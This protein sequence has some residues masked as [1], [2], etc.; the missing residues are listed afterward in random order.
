MFRSKSLLL[1]SFAI[2]TFAAKDV[3]A[4]VPYVI[5]HSSGTYTPIT[6]GTTHAPVAYGGFSALDEGSVGIPIPFSFLW[7]G[8]SYTTVHAYTNGLVSF[9]PPPASLAGQLRQ[10]NVVPSQGNLLHNFIGVM[11]HDLLMNMGTSAIRSQVTGAAGSRVLTIQFEDF[12]GFSNPASTVNFQVRLFEGSNAVQVKFGPN[13]LWQQANGGTTAIENSDGTDGLNLMDPSPT[14][15]A[16]CAC[17]PARC[18]TSN[19]VVGHTIDI[20]LPMV[21][22]LTATISAPPGARANTM[23]DAD[24]EIFNSGLTAAGAFQYQIYLTPTNTS[25]AG[26]TSIGTFSVPS[27][28]SAT[29]LSRT[30]T[31]TVPP[32]FPVGTYY[33]AVKVDTQFLINEAREDNNTSFSADF[34]TGPD[35][36]GSILPPSD[37]GPGEPFSIAFSVRSLGAPV[38]GPIS[39]QIYLSATQTFDMMT[40]IPVGPA[41]IT[42]T[43]GFAFDGNVSVTMPVSVPPSPPRYYVVAVLDDTNAEV[44]LD[45]TNNVLV[46]PN[47]V[48]VRGPDIEGVSYDSGPFAFRGLTYPSTVRLTNSGGA[49]AIDFTVCVYLSD[50]LLI[51]VTSDTQLLETPPMT[52]QPGEQRTLSLEPMIPVQTAT[53]TWYIAA[54]L[55]CGE[56]IPEAVETNNTERR[57]DP[58]TVRDPSPDLLP[59]AIQA[60]GT[61]AAAETTPVTVDYGNTGN[62]NGTAVIR[63]SLSDNPGITIDDPVLL[64]TTMPVTLAPTETAAF[65]DWVPLPPETPSGTYYIGAIID[66]DNRADETYEDNNAIASGPVVVTGTDL[67]IVTP[68]PP[69]AIYDVPYSRRFAAVGGSQ[70]Y[71]WTITWQSGSAP[72]GLAFD[73]TLAEISGTPSRSAEGVHPFE[74]TVTSGPLVAR[75]TYQLIV[76]G[77][78]I[79]LQVVS[80]RLPPALAQE[81]YSVQLVAVGGVPPYRW[82]LVDQ[83]PFGL[84]L[85]SDGLLGGEPQLVDSRTFR[86]RVADATEATADGLL[87][88]DIVDP[89]VSVSIQQADVA[90]GI[91]NVEYETQFSAAGGTPPYDWSLEGTIPGLTFN[92]STALLTGTPTVAGEYPIVVEVRDADGLLDRNAYVLEIAP[93]GAL[94]IVTGTDAEN[95]LPTA[96]LNEAYLTADGSSVRL[97]ATDSEVTWSIVAGGLPPGLEL[98]ANSGIISGTPSIAGAFP[99]VVLATNASNDTRRAALAVVVRD[100]SDP[101]MVGPEPSCGC[102]STETSGSSW[103]WLLVVPLLL[104][105]R[106]RCL[107][108]VAFALMLL[109]STAS[110]QSPYR[111]FTQ[112]EPFV[113]LGPSAVEIN[114]GLGDGGTVPIQLPFAVVLYG[115][116]YSTLQVNANGWVSVVT[117][118]FGF[119]TPASVNPDTTHPNGFYAPLWA[120]WCASAVGCVG[121]ANPG[122]GIFYEVDTTPGQGSITIEWRNMRH[123]ADDRVPSN[124]DFQVRIHEGPAALVEMMYGP[125]MPG[126]NVGGGNVD[127]R[128][129]IGIESADGARGMFVGPCVATTPCTTFEV[130]SLTNTKISIIAD[131]GEDLTLSSLGAAPSGYAGLPLPVTVRLSSRHF[132]P[133]GPFRYEA[134]LLGAGATSTVG[135]T[136]LFQSAPTT[137]QG[138]ETRVAQFD[139]EV[140]LSLPDGTYRAA[141]AID[142]DHQIDE[143]DETNNLEVGT[144]DVVIG[145]RAPDFRA[146]ALRSVDTEGAPGAPIDVTY[147][148]ENFGNEPAELGFRLVLS[149]NSAITASDVALGTD[150]TVTLDRREVHTATVSVMVPASLTTGRYHLG[151]LLDPAFAVAELDE[152]NNV[153]RAADT[154][155][156]VASDVSVLTTSLPAGALATAYDVRFEAAG[157]DGTFVWSLASGSLPSGM[158]FD[159]Q[160]GR[161]HGIPLASG[162]FELGVR[163]ESGGSA[164]E[165][166]VSLVVLD[167][168]YALVMQTRALPSAVLGSDYSV[169]LDAAGGTPPYRFRIT[170]GALP[171]GIVMAPDGAI[172]GTPRRG[173]FA[174]FAVEVLDDATATATV[175]L[176]L[177]VRSP[178][179]LTIT[180]A[181]L[182]S[183]RLGAPYTQ[184]LFASGGRGDLRWS[185]ITAPPPGVVVSAEGLVSG[186]P[187]L[188]G[189]FRFAVQVTDEVGKTDTALLRMTVETDDL[190]RIITT[191]IP[192]GEPAVAYE[193]DILAEGGE[194]PFACEI[195]RRDG[196]LPPGFDVVSE[197]DG[198]AIDGLRISGTPEREGV[199]S[200]SVVCSDRR[201]RSDEAAFALVVETPPEVV[202]EDGGCGCATTDDE[203]GG[204]LL[205]LALLLAL[206]RRRR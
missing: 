75:R 205:G 197:I 88:L 72:D 190:F 113:P 64:E 173:G 81:R 73:T 160:T 30:H 165:V 95:T 126:T 185:A 37:S 176:G 106:R 115:E 26:G 200:F 144:T 150:R 9:S 29:S 166:A 184:S 16:A 40:A 157:G 158:V 96:I 3:S 132:E 186:I 104:L 47:T 46:S 76:S 136:A 139:L 102:T 99:F 18:G 117:D 71:A 169:G 177:E 174:V 203:S 28:G 4:Q 142:A 84:A 41:S 82:A 62:A 5:T 53:G 69:N 48:N 120:D 51:S 112:S 77:P 122:M 146:V 130:Q 156:V 114:P 100:P 180:S 39:T 43:D 7:Y 171:E 135:V 137:L 32:G 35:L 125:A 45:E 90:A 153:A 131:A 23:F 12:R 145:G 14:C 111:V 110:A 149:E 133:V 78:T 181:S 31:L 154:V 183:G 152:A 105:R 58:I 22:E 11:W 168:D 198:E 65:A 80:S 159:G 202:E 134:Y 21:P 98:A 129:R 61:A 33:V 116:P 44:E 74:L 87:S 6:G 67:A 195:N 192:A 128:A 42:L 121:V 201:G 54:V 103:A 13:A 148:L 178:G 147:T 163:A 20:D 25:T 55:D 57:L 162:T 124:V 89:S 109:S 155:L 85:D 167:P 97:R 79:P 68:H 118:V 123:F 182:A 86:V 151:V 206:T 108:A 15:S 138:F 143:T 194:R 93:E 119:H 1:A 91:A 56:V 27:L 60:S 10:P 52:L 189:D 191:A 193:T 199:W 36:T 63:I 38:S 161:L 188:I 172:F 170:S 70:P 164:D 83:A 107:L 19:W 196:F 34:G 50:N 101:T 2:A 59:L 92:T 187:E 49:R 141:V 140:P 175:S 179:N 8:Q 94:R 17:Q 204:E 24:V 66:P 127:F